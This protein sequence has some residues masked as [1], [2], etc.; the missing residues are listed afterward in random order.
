VIISEAV[1]RDVTGD[2]AT[3]SGSI[4]SALIGAQRRVEEATGRE[5]E[6]GVRTEVLDVDTSDGR[7][8]WPHGYPLH[9]VSAPL[10]STIDGTSIQNFG[11]GTRVAI[12]YTSGFDED[13]P[14]EQWLSDII[15][16][17]AQRR[18]HPVDTSSVPAGATQVATARGRGFSGALGGASALP[19]HITTQLRK[20]R[21][22]DQRSPL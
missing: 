4:R 1:Y 22:F 19:P 13:H 15:V 5:F 7:R 2:R 21:H 10:G 9:A 6:P 12:T 8:V 17:V 20:I 3:P 16:E 14:V 11:P 18:L